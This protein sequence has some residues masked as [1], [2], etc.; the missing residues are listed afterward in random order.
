MSLLDELKALQIRVASG[1]NHKDE[2]ICYNLF[3]DHCSGELEALNELFTLWPKFSG[4]VGYPIYS[5]SL[6][7]AS[8]KNEYIFYQRRSSLW[9]E[10]TEYGKL[11]IE[12][13]QFCIDYL[14][15]Q[16]GYHVIT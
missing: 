7:H 15:K 13:L 1:T 2:G 4:N 8:A 3:L 9:D 6:R 5:G 14:E 11:R 12:L 10:K 16:E